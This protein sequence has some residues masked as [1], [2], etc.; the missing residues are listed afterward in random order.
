MYSAAPL[1][2]AGAV[3]VAALVLFALAGSTPAFAS[4]A[5]LLS[6]CSGLVLSEHIV[7]RREPL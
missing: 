4:A 1:A 5:F 3:G 2:V 7:Y 6:L